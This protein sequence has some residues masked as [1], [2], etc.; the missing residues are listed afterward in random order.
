[1]TVTR[2]DRDGKERQRAERVSGF[3]ESDRAAKKSK[4]GQ[5]RNKDRIEICQDDGWATNEEPP[6][7]GVQNVKGGGRV[8][9]T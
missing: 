3:R 4:E 8:R 7:Q 6:K 9:I 5:R 2:F 1:V